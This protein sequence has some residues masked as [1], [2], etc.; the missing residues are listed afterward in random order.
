MQVWEERYT[1]NKGKKESKRTFDIFQIYDNLPLPRSISELTRQVYYP[2]EKLEKA[3]KNKDWLKKY[4]SI[5]SLYYNYDFDER[6]TLHD[7]YTN[8]QIN[9]ALSIKGAEY[10]LKI[11]E[12]TVSRITLADSEADRMVRNNT[13]KV[14]VGEELLERPKRDKD[15]SKSLLENQQ[16]RSLAVDDFFKLVNDNVVRTENKNDNT[17]TITD[18]GIDYFKD[19][20][21]YKDKFNVNDFITED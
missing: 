6:A 18:E 8:K 14:V 16:M 12:K 10:R 17:H 2:N 9:E 5:Y 11:F 4:N 3:R 19:K 7:N 13:E 21:E 1:N 20:E 15:Q